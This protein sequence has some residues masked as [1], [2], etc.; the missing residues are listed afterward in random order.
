LTGFKAESNKTSPGGKRKSVLQV[1]IHCP[2][3]ES[4]QK[5]HNQKELFLPKDNFIS[6]SYPQRQ[7]LFVFI[8]WCA[9]LCKAH[10]ARHCTRCISAV[11]FLFSEDCLLEQAL[12]MRASHEVLSTSRNIPQRGEERL[13]WA[14]LAWGASAACSGWVRAADPAHGAA[15][16]L[17]A[18]TA[19][20][21]KSMVRSRR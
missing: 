10:C 8:T 11:D 13:S 17:R 14:P 15:P 18:A 4:Q 5:T 7:P 2:K 12:G 20:C 1:V 19:P 21:S 16:L 3:A 9:Q 6:C